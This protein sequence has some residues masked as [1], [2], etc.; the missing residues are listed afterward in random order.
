MAKKHVTKFEQAINFLKNL[1]VVR[2][3]YDT[4]Y[5]VPLLLLGIVFYFMFQHRS[6]IKFLLNKGKTLTTKIISNGNPVDTQ[7]KDKSYLETVKLDTISASPDSI[8]A[9]IKQSVKAINTKKR[10][11]E[12]LL[13]NMK[14]VEL[15]TPMNQIM[16]E[17]K[18]AKADSITLE[19]SDMQNRASDL[20]K[21]YGDSISNLIIN[22]DIDIIQDRKIR[23]VLPIIENAKIL[24]VVICNNDKDVYMVFTD[25]GLF[26]NFIKE[27]KQ[28]GGVIMIG[29]PSVPIPDE[30]INN[31]IT[32]KTLNEYDIKISENT[33][34]LKSL[35]SKRSHVELWFNCKIQLKYVA[36]LLNTIR[37]LYV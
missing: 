4:W 29:V 34:V 22:A 12:S 37:R 28:S 32:Y 6:D 10:P 2:F 18:M 24:G 27:R 30:Y 16:I 14:I 5:G 23:G 17:N 26:Y 9:V 35:N 19:E 31:G 25:E 21:N 11:T 33:L 7:I 1:K 15:D 13:K 8:K 3:F 20:I 36:D